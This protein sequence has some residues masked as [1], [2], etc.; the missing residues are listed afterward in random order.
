MRL[1][2]RSDK[3]TLAIVRRYAS[4]KAPYLGVPVFDMAAGRTVTA[5]FHRPHLQV[6]TEAAV[7][8]GATVTYDCEAHTLNFNSVK[9]CCY[10][11]IDLK[12]SGKLQPCQVKAELESWAR[13]RRKS[14]ISRTLPREQR[15]AERLRLEIGKLR[16]KQDKIYA[17]RPHHPLIPTS[18]DLQ[19][20]SEYERQSVL[21][22]IRQ[23]PVRRR[24][25]QL[26]RR[27]RK[28]WAQFYRDVEAIIGRHVDSSQR[29]D[30]VTRRKRHGRALGPSIVEYLRHLYRYVGMAQKIST[31]EAWSPYKNLGWGDE[32]DQNEFQRHRNAQRNYLAAMAEK[33]AL[34]SEIDAHKVTIAELEGKVTP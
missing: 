30:V 6:A 7:H 11:L 17:S 20:A 16:R 21:E 32:H 4:G 3:V 15:Q 34:Q 14:A 10:R 1:R 13:G 5:V 23:K 24:L 18:Y 9:G 19:P 2:D 29:H 33:A 8:Y 31:L 28:T 22:W 12:Q 26:V 27:E 25:G